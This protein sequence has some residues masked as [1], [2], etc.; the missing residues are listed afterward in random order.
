MSATLNGSQESHFAPVPTIAPSVQQNLDQPRIVIH[1][2]P[3]KTGTT[4]LQSA[5]ARA[6]HTLLKQG[7]F[8]P[9]V[10]FPPDGNTSHGLIYDLLR[11]NDIDLLTAQLNEV[12]HT[13]CHTAVISSEALADLSAAE[14]ASLRQLTLGYDT[15]V[16]IYCRSWVARM[17]SGWKETVRHGNTETLPEFCA[18]HLGNASQSNQ[19]NFGVLIEEYA[20][21]FGRDSIYLVCYDHLVKSGTNLAEHFLARFCGWNGQDSP[22]PKMIYESLSVFEA[23]IA[24]SLNVL[25]PM[26]GERY[27][28]NLARF[29]NPELEESMRCHVRRFRINE[30]DPLLRRIHDEVYTNFES[31]IV[32][33]RPIGCLFEMKACE[34]DYVATDYLL[35]ATA[36][37][38]LLDLKCALEA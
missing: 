3:H 5:L 4:F 37:Q 20:R 23:E 2:G 34:V 26:L 16:V 27:V 32:D 25:N 8:Y 22:P 7:I 35:E 14:I 28:W 21:Q 31:R 38:Q 12:L 18:I 33:P 6:R 10:W 30:A 13:A 17:V 24:R 1:V 9:S 11:K 36:R 19:V 15:R 29:A